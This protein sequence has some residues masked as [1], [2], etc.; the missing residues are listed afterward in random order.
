[1][2]HDEMIA[3]LEANKAEEE[4]HLSFRVNQ[5][6]CW[7]NGTEADH[8]AGAR[9]ARTKPIPKA[10]RLELAAIDDRIAAKTSVK[11]AAYGAIIDALRKASPHA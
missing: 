9:M 3:F 1:M 6:D 4:K 5:A 7:R 10:R 2:T 8:L 11:I